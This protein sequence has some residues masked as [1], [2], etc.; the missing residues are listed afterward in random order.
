MHVARNLTL[1]FLLTFLAVACSKDE[2]IDVSKAKDVEAQ[3]YLV[4]TR[5]ASSPA[6]RVITTPLPGED[7]DGHKYGTVDESTVSNIYA[8]FYDA[9]YQVSS[10]ATAPD[11]LPLVGVYFDEWESATQVNTQGDDTTAPY[12]NRYQQTAKKTVGELSIGSSYR[13]LAVANCD[14]SLRTKLDGIKTMGELRRAVTVALPWTETDGRFTDF[15]MASESDD[16]VLTFTT[17]AEAVTPTQ[18]INLERVAARV[19]YNCKNADNTFTFN[20]DNST[21]SVTILGATLFNVANA[22]HT[23]YLLK[24]VTST[25]SPTDFSAPVYLGKEEPSAGNPNQAAAENYVIDPYTVDKA[26]QTGDG[27]NSSMWETLYTN[28]FAT[29]KDTASFYAD[30]KSR[31]VLPPSTATSTDYDPTT[32]YATIGYAVENIAP[33]TA[34]ADN[35][36]FDTGIVFRAKY[37]KPQTLS[38]SAIRYTYKGATYSASTIVD[39]LTQML[40]DTY[41]E[42]HSYTN[43][44]SWWSPQYYWSDVNDYYTNTLT[45]KDDKLGYAAYVKNLYDNRGT[46]YW[47]YNTTFSSTNSLTYSYYITNTLFSQL[48]ISRS[49]NGYYGYTYT[50]NASTAYSSTYALLQA[51]GFGTDVLTSNEMQE[52]YGYYIYYIRH[53]ADDDPAQEGIME[54]AIVR[55]NLYQVTVNSISKTPTDPFTKEGIEI[56]VAVKDWNK[57]GEETIDF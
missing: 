48:N 14:A 35:S 5:P 47:G 16:P 17:G 49:S 57:L 33:K 38:S 42:E 54:H 24:R 22:D 52:G 8:F 56:I 1:L 15:L 51:M 7:G 50:L 34:S 43:H 30:N 39:M 41:G 19:D 2:V 29:I 46:N 31:F 13:V 37:Q 27:Y 25:T 3:V 55:N 21:V 45:A 23:S 36:H 6:T 11:D 20:E 44:G 32:D 28:L 26:K 9:S 53:A 12:V 4:V 40:K 10:L 18:S